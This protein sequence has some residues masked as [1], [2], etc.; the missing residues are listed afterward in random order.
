[1]CAPC[2]FPSSQS[3]ILKETVISGIDLSAQPG[4]G[5]S[6]Q[7]ARWEQEPGS[8]VKSV[9][10]DSLRPHAIY[11]PWNLARILESVAFP[12]SRGSSKLKDRTQV[13]CIAGSFFTS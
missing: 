2:T 5:C 4:H 6:E 8:E 13:S 12:F 3:A 11:S 1:M 9:V 7:Q 10:S